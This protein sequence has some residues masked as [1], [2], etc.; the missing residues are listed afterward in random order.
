M[1][2]YIPCWD[3]IGITKARYMELLYFCRQYPE[4]LSDERSMLGIQGHAMDGQPH[5]TLTGDPVFNLVVKRERIL[6]KIELVEGCAKRVEG[7]LWF[8]ALIKNVCGGCPHA[9]I[10]QDI[11]PTANRNAFYQAR[12]EFFL[13]LDAETNK[14][15]DLS[16]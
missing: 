14:E 11:M 3:K 12:K 6:R 15:A 1:R 16:K 9:K 2:N 4:W 10:K 13:L 7:G 8:A 5:G